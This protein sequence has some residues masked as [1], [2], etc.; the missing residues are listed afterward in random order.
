M[1][2]AKP[3]VRCHHPV[4]L[5]DRHAL[6][7]CPPASKGRDGNRRKAKLK[8]RRRRRREASLV[9]V[10]GVTV[11]GTGVPKGAQK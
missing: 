8:A 11:A 1:R 3:C 9:P 5:G 4:G 2:Q 7:A 10:R 6:T